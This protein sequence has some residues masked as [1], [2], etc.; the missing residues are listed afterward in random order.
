MTDQKQFLD[1]QNRS[2]DFHNLSMDDEKKLLEQF[3]DKKY[4]EFL[5]DCWINRS[6]RPLEKFEDRW[7]DWKP[8]DIWSYPIDDLIRYR[9]MIL[10]NS[11]LIKGYNVADIGSHLGV[12][13][14]FSLNLGANR[15]VGVE[16]FE[17]KNTLA[18]MICSKAGFENFN[19][20][21]GELKQKNI[22]QKIS[23]F[24]TLI[25]GSLIDMIPNH[26]QLIENVSTTGIKNIIIEM[27]DR[28]NADSETPDIEWQYFDND[29]LRHG[30]LNVD[31][32][33]AIHGYPNLA[34][35]K[36]LLGEFGYEFQ[37]QTNFH[38]NTKSQKPRR[39]SVSTF[40]R[41]TDRKGML[42]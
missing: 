5:H 33:K 21:T 24:D 15:C 41:L 29:H 13:V 32:E 37:K 11:H 10:D 18:S 2:R 27:E 19:F 8:W 7:A 35:L 28:K 9:H 40:T 20:I 42:N 36:M 22:Y 6:E 30:P 14:L 17:M 31:K 3:P 39:R 12:G 1:D 4:F 16:P 26:Y 34:F 23:G 38:V 25:L